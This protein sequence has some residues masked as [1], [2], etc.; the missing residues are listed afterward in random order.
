MKTKA[1][2]ST[3]DLAPSTRWHRRNGRRTIE[4]AAKDR[5]YLTIQ[6]E[7]VLM[8]AVCRKLDAGLSTPDQTIRKFACEI[9]R[10][11]APT[12]KK[13]PGRNWV[14]AFKKRQMKEMSS[15]LA[16]SL[17]WQRET[18]SVHD[19][20]P[21]F[22]ATSSDLGHLC[23]ECTKIS[24][25]LKY[26]LSPR[27]TESRSLHTFKKLPVEVK[28]TTCKL[29]RFILL[30][31]KS[32]NWPQTGKLLLHVHHA[33]NIFGS[34]IAGGPILLSLSTWNPH[35]QKIC[36]GWIVPEAMIDPSDMEQES[37]VMLG[38]S[39]D[40][41]SITTW[42]QF[43]ENNH[44]YDCGVL[45]DDDIPYFRLINCKDRTIVDGD[46]QSKYA[47]LSYCWGKDSDSPPLVIEDALEVARRLDIPFLWIDRYCIAQSDPSIKPAQLEN[48]H[49]VYR[50]AYVTIVAG[51]GDGSQF[52]LPG[53]STRS[54]KQQA[55]VH[56]HG[57]RLTCIP[58]VVEEIANCEWSTRGW[59]F[60]E[61]LY[62]R[63]RLVF[64]ETQA[65]FQCR[66][67]HCC[68]SVPIELEKAHIKNL[69]R[70]KEHLLTLRAFPQKGVLKSRSEIDQRIH[71]YVG[72]FLTH[73]SDAL[74]AFLG[75]FQEFQELEFPIYHFWGLPMSM[76]GWNDSSAMPQT[77]SEKLHELHTS[78]LSSLAWT[79]SSCDQ[80]NTHLLS[81]RGD[82]PTWS[83]AA[84]KVLCTFSRKPI[85][86][87]VCSPSVRLRRKESRFETLQAYANSVATGQTFLSYEPCIYLNGWVTSIRFAVDSSHC[88]LIPNFRVQCPVPTRRVA[89]TMDDE[90]LAWF[91]REIS[92]ESF[93][94]LVLGN[95]SSCEGENDATL[96]RFSNL[97]AVVL[98]P[99]PNNSH[100]RLGVVTWS[101]LGAPV[102]DKRGK[103]L[104]VKELFEA[105]RVEPSC[106]CGCK[107]PGAYPFDRYLED[108]NHVLEFKKADIK[109]A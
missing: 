35:I 49:K 94:A 43:C 100:I 9:K 32:W 76:F 78:F 56:T 55:V 73:D 72:R 61:S 26:R 8:K 91:Q 74:N 30:C 79:G 63:R 68:E 14:T 109:L 97:R 11:R 39:V 108:D 95:L 13:P 47:A 38:R 2:P 58:D 105:R 90:T 5:G 98:R 87:N 57:H 10:Q 3:E 54:R 46:S 103:I 85:V 86:K 34:T 81:R 31:C 65:Y 40:F 101:L 52:G 16:V 96:S 45:G 24:V 53:V 60:Q 36:R 92:T 7:Q 25:K 106:E 80:G 75:I 41:D 51:A 21:G 89:L 6:E 107:T 15:E 70:F 50:S 66:N 84:W 19:G 93:Q 4:E 71:E 48:M 33:D 28:K 29:C 77:E 20:L 102:L 104:R 17:G 42:L 83:W 27:P 82:F 12:A 99:G 18:I 1:S 44:F 62:S 37:P 69:K 88:R 22:A 64:T 67:M 23:K 59:T